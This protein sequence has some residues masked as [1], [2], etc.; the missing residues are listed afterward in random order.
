MNCPKCNAEMKNI[1]LWPDFGDNEKIKETF[2]CEAC[3]EGPDKPMETIRVE[4][5]K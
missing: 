5:V 4:V 2:V 1:G 3:R